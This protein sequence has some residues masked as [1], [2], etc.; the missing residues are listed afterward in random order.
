MSVI[1]QRPQRLQQLQAMTV[2]E[3]FRHIAPEKLCI[4]SVDF[5]A[6]KPASTTAG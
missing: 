1:L 6:R 5:I 3:Q 4:T 2:A